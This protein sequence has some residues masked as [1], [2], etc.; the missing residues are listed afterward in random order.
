MSSHDKH[1]DD[2]EKIDVHDGAGEI[3]ELTVVAE[4][5]ERT[6]W[7]VWV[8]VSCSTISGLLFGYD[9]G[10][11][12]GALVT[13]GSD[14][15]PALLSDG[16]K[17]FITSSTT[18]GALLGG[19]AAGVISDWIGR[20]PVLG[21][22]DIIF[23]AGAI[24]QA[25]CHDVWSMIG[26]RFLIG[27]GVG[28]ASCVAPLYIQELSPTRLRGRMVVLNVVMITLGQVIAYAIGAG[29]F[30]VKS[31]W[32]WMVGLGAVPA[33][34][35]FV[36]L[37]FLPESPRILLQRGNIDGAR[38]IMNK[39]Y[40]HATVEQLDLKVRVLNQAVSE[41]VHITQ[42]TTLFHRI[43]S[44]L[45]DSVNRRALII[46]CGIQ[47][48]QQ[49]CG[50]N[51]LMYYSA[52]LFA[53]IGFDQPTAVGLIVSG[54][55][56][57]FT[58]IAL[59]WIDSIGRR[60]IM[61]VSAPGMIVGLTLASIAFHF[62]TLKTGN[63]LV[64]GSDYSRGWS[65]IVLLSMI[66]FVASYATGL[67]NVPWQQG[68]L[69]SLEVRGLGTSL[70]TA[71]NWSANLLINSTY[72]SLMAKIT[73][74]GAFGFYAGLCL[75]GYIFVVFCFP[76]LAGL[77]LEEVTAVFRGGEKGRDGKTGSFWMTIKE[78]ERLRKMKKE[79]RNREIAKG[80]IG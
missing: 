39:I 6:T 77:S 21:I 13:I 33:G 50:F 35:Q 53:Q 28:L 65:A 52:T 27:V 2:I 34:I 29:F 23:V 55:N 78:G 44:M 16:Q 8:L 11:I 20:R 72:L 26:G 19:L 37:F 49:L 68:E 32:R 43:K 31:G 75:L 48:Y 5:E 76:E 25:V 71:T 24:A 62:M 14:L 1:E 64:A 80:T 15:G 46:A 70:A 36:L 38:A 17:E 3:T 61:L 10:V 30:H 4:G 59:K 56:F 45:L 79:I 18:L 67:G 9:T 51:T 47:A 40:A 57:I 63:I 66:V 73:P 42:T 69:F 58:L 41:A 7:F 60:R 54:T 12:S 22:A 74:A